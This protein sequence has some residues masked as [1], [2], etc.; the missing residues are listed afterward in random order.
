MRLTENRRV[1]KPG[2]CLC[3]IPG[4]PTQIDLILTTF[5]SAKLFVYGDG[6]ESD[7]LERSIVNPFADQNVCHAMAE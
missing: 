3:F 2:S 4:R 5:G 7:P 1:T 6:E